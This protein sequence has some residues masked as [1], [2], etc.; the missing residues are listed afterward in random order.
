LSSHEWIYQYIARDKA[1]G[2]VLYQSLRQGHKRY[3]RRSGVT[4]SP[5]KDTV[6][7]DQRPFIVDTHLLLGDWEADAVLG[8]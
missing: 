6:S 3:R 1:A 8:K 4:R 5:I 7:M 2:G